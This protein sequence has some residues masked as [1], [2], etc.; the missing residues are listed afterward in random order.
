MG[1]IDAVRLPVG[2]PASPIAGFVRWAS[3]ITVLTGEA[4]VANLGRLV[5]VDANAP[6]RIDAQLL[7]CC[8]RTGAHGRI[9][10][11]AEADVDGDVPF[12]PRNHGRAAVSPTQSVCTRVGQR[13]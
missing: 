12:A 7:T 5:P 13:D 11:I 2:I 6:G 1:E 4:P 10:T 9:C 3:S 8:E